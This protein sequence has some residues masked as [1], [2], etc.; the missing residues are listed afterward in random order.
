VELLLP[1][2]TRIVEVGRRD[3][4]QAVPQPLTSAIDWHHI[5]TTPGKALPTARN[6]D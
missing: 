2:R 3:G 6:T 4:L 1:C 5:L